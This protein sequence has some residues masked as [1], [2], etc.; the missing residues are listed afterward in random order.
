VN[1]NVLYVA[2]I[3]ALVAAVVGLLFWSLRRRKEIRSEGSLGEKLE[4][5]GSHIVYLAQVRRAIDGKDYEYLRLRGS[6]RLSRRVKKE[7]RQVALSYLSALQTDFDR[8]LRLA[9][10]LATLSP[11]AVPAQ[12]WERLRLSLWFSV[13][14]RALKLKILLGWG[15]LPQ[16]TGISQ[17][18]SGLALRLEHAMSELGERAALASEPNST[19]N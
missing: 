2:L 4:A 17:T 7:R 15:I 10:V 9:R 8:L 1:A 3:L 14:C 5:P 12:E 13:R 18:V 11:E 19:V 16:L 6:Q